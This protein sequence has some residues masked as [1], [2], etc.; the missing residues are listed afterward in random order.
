VRGY[1]YRAGLPTWSPARWAVLRHLVAAVAPAERAAMEPDVEK[2]SEQVSRLSTPAGELAATSDRLAAALARV[3]PRL[4]AVDWTEGRARDLLAAVA[5][6]RAYLEAADRESAEQA[7]L[8]VQ[9][10]VAYLSDRRSSVARGP[11]PGKVRALFATL[12]DPNKFDRQRF[13]EVL[14]G[15]A[16]VVPQR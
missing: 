1:R 13:G 15:V 6:D 8:A 14:G 4:A 7:A 12:D 2:L 16:E 5:A 9:S 3:L 11:L 10:L